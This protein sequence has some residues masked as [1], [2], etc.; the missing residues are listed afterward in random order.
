MVVLDKLD[1]LS[2]CRGLSK[3]YLQRLVSAG[4]VETYQ[5]G[6]RLF[7]EGQS[8]G[9]IYLLMEGEVALETLIP[10]QGP[11][12]IQTVGRGELLGWSPL[13]GL[14]VMSATAR[15]L[16]SCRALALNA[17]RILAMGEEDPAFVLEIM[18]RTAIT[19]AQRLNGTRLQLLEAY[20]H[21]TQ[22]VS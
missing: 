18:R 13:L 10:G 14:G 5:P 17:G 16:T 21:E 2:F 22:V 15:A 9:N 11:M 7:S 8:S 4:V 3:D 6:E 1:Q 12:R 20:C 19:L